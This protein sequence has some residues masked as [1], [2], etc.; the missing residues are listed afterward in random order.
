[1]TLSPSKSSTKTA[2]NRLGSLARGSVAN[3]SGAA[4]SSVATLALTLAVTRGVS[5]Q[6][7]GIFFAASSVFMLAAAVSQL[8]TSLGL[9]YFLSR[10][11]SFGTPQAF[12]PLYRMATRPTLVVSVALGVLVFALAPQLSA[13]VNTER[14]DLS[15][16]YLRCMAVFLPLMVLTQVTLSGTRG[17]G[18]MRPNVLTEQI[19]RPLIQLALVVLCVLTLGESG[20]GLAWAAAYLP[21]AFL[22]LLYWRRMLAQSERRQEPEDPHV[23]AGDGPG[24]AGPGRGEFWRFTSPRALAAVAQMT[25]QRFDIVLVAA[26]AGAVPAAIYTAATRFLVVGQAAQRAV[27][28]AMQPRLAE[29]LAVDDRD[30]ARELYRL[31]TAWLMLVTWPIYLT[32]VFFGEQLLAI[33]G[34]DYSA[35]ATVLLLLSLTM[36]FATGCGMV[37]IVL[38][39]AGR[40]TW[41]LYNVLLSLVVQVGVDIWLIPDYGILGA[42]IGWAAAIAAANLVPL[43]QVGKVYGLHPFGRPTLVAFLAL[44]TCFGLVPAVTTAVLGQGLTG[45]A[46]SSAVG[47][48][49]YLAVLWLARHSLELTALAHITR[50]KAA[51]R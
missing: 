14:V 35:G 39:M 40:S 5:P 27:S 25:M 46:V 51:A 3:L 23:G 13:V 10:A 1:M 20:L 22:A 4:F 41:S 11:R 34:S 47:G 31:A 9:V 42:A 8:G 18:S 30:R 33:F 36:L 44:V 26:L 32:F 2:P 24:P 7:A 38:V 21:A 29:A 49:A 37:D 48:G 28:L 16:V 50:R 43:A 6:V 15:T 12:R 17:L 19:G 45:L